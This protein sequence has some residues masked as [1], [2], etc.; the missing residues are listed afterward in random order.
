MSNSAISNNSIDINKLK[1]SSFDIF[2]ASAYESCL[3]LYQ[4]CQKYDL[5][6]PTLFTSEDLCFVTDHPFI[7]VATYN[8]TAVGCCLVCATYDIERELCIYVHPD[9]RRCGIGSRLL[10]AVIDDYEEIYLI[11]NVSPDNTGGIKFLNA[12]NFEYDGCECKME[13]HN[14]LHQNLSDIITLPSHM[15]ISKSIESQGDILYSLSINSNQIGSCH[16][17][18]EDKICVIHDVL[19]DEKYRDKGYATMML[20]SV[21]SS[22]LDTFERILLHV[23]KENLPAYNLYINLGF[24]VTDEVLVYVL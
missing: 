17:F 15:K 4:L 14:S 19:I 16:I 22:E 21:L 2:S 23:T 20:R 10:D 24:T 12:M 9:Y 6:V 8:D 18:V 11:S 3:E 7:Y 13:L 5:S 1:I